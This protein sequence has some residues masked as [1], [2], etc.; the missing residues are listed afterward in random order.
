MEQ[1]K[2]EAGGPGK[3]FAQ[4]WEMVSELRQQDGEWKK[5]VNKAWSRDSKGLGGS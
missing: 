3:V 4:A 2:E 5:T 1:D